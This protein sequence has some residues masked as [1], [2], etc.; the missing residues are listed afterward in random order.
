MKNFIK[1]YI[2]ARIDAVILSQLKEVDFDN[3]VGEAAEEKIGRLNLEREAENAL[4]TAI[5]D[6]DLNRELENAIETAVND[7]DVDSKVE[8]ALTEL[9]DDMRNKIQ[10][11]GLEAFFKAVTGRSLRITLFGKT[12][13]IKL[14]EGAIE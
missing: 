3:I 2:N 6:L 7:V 10:A 5:Q 14:E 13:S 1:T 8:D 11:G 9:T 4:E 12:F